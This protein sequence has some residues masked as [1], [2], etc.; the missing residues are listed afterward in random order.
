VTPGRCQALRARRATLQAFK[1]P[2][3][4]TL[5]IAAWTASSMTNPGKNEQPRSWT[6]T[7]NPVRGTG[8]VGADQ[9]RRRSRSCGR[10]RA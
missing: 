6:A 2:T 8:G 9:D 1:A 7:A 4:P 10:G 3:D 5:K